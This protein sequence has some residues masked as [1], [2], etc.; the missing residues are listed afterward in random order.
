MSPGLTLHMVQQSR[1][2][3]QDL[4]PTDLNESLPRVVAHRKPTDEQLLRETP[5]HRSCLQIF[6]AGR[7][8]GPC[9]HMSPGQLKSPAQSS[10]PYGRCQP[11]CLHPGNH[12]VGLRPG[13]NNTAIH[14]IHMPKSTPPSLALKST[15]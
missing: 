9:H 4:S 7:L 6:T 14:I 10:G 5:Q 12:H 13:L 1:K 11:L 2:H 15:W 3:E 8:E